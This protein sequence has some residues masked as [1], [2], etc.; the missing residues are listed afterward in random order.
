MSID[1]AVSALRV[2]DFR[3]AVSTNNV[4][5][6]FTPDF[7]AS[8]AIPREQ[9]TQQGVDAYS[10][11]TDHGTDLAEE[12]VEQNVVLSYAKANGKVIKVHNEMFG[13]LIDMF[14]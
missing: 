5:N 10:V 14:G 7:K 4:A 13:S 9:V 6:M 1:T 3:L 8:R 11:K 12:M 2:A